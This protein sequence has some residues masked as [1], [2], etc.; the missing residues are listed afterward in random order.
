MVFGK[1]ETKSEETPRE[2]VVA[3]LY[4]DSPTNEVEVAPP[5]NEFR[6]EDRGNESVI[7]PHARFNGKYVSDRD[8]RI[9]GEAQ[10]EIECQGTLI[11]SPQ[12]RVRSAIKA[13]NVVING[14]YEGDVDCGGRFE[15]GSTGRVKGEVKT[16]V[17]VVK[18]G[19]FMEGSVRMS[20]DGTAG[21]RPGQATEGQQ[22]SRPGQ[23]ATGSGSLFGK[24][25]RAGQP[26][27]AGDRGSG[28]GR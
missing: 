23:P 14:D 3:D 4:P 22:A 6:R 5:P 21:T 7:D 10:G 25:D 11:I 16:Q 9:E 8:L 18:E 26:T 28:G 17:L 12:A 27:A 24:G 19:A 13:H 2:D 20:R 1:R 15:I